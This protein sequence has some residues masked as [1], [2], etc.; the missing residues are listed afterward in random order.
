MIRQVI[1]RLFVFDHQASSLVNADA[2]I[3]HQ[4]EA[5]KKVADDPVG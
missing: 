2:G 4:R 5:D 1:I 3:D